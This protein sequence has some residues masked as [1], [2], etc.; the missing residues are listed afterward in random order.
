MSH[1]S[2]RSTQNRSEPSGHSDPAIALLLALKHEKRQVCLWSA[3]QYHE[4]F[5]THKKQWLIEGGMWYATADFVLQQKLWFLFRSVRVYVSWP[6]MPSK[7]SEINKHMAFYD[8]QK[9]F[10]NFLS[11]YDLVK[12]N[13]WS[14]EW[15][16]VS[17]QSGDHTEH[18]PSR[19][20]SKH[21]F[22]RGAWEGL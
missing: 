15:L 12:Q 18:K 1:E 3:M 14:R 19:H 8:W 11:A 20:L 22:N 21:V 17:C 10:A 5:Q 4:C 2:H 13:T 9:I 6:Q 16:C 7:N